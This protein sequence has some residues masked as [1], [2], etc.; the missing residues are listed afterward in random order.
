[1][2]VASTASC[3]A[4]LCADQASAHAGLNDLKA[5]IPFRLDRRSVKQLKPPAAGSGVI[6]LAQLVHELEFVGIVPNA[7]AGNQGRH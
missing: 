4:E 6:L 7:V 1:M 5:T 2:I 3:A